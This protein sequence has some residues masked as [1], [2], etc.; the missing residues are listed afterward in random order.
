MS[1]PASSIVSV[2]PSV[3]A[4]GGNPLALNGLILSGN[5]LLPVGPPVSFPSAASVAAYFGNYAASFVGSCATNVLTVSQINSGTLA[6][7]QAVLG[8]SLPPNTYISSLGSG[9]GGVGTYNLSTTPGTIGPEAMTSAPLETAMAAV[10]FSGFN[11]S[12]TKPNALWFSKYASYS[13]AAFQCGASRSSLNTLATLHAITGSLVLNV[14]GLTF[15]AAAVASAFSGAASPSAAA[16]ALTALFTFSGAAVG[17]TITWSSTFNAFVVSTPVGS[18]TNTVAYATGTAA[19]A[20][21]LDA[22]SAGTLSQGSAA[23]TPAGAMAAVVLA[24]QNWAAFTTAFEPVAADK[25]AFA[26]WNS[27]TNGQFLYVP[28]DTDATAPTTA[29][30]TFTGLGAWLVTNSI[31]GTMPVYSDPLVAALM[32]GITASIDFTQHNGRTSFAFKSGSGLT[33][34]VSDLTSATNLLS[35][36]YN[37]YGAYATANSNFIWSQN[38]QISGPYLWADSYVNA[39]WLNNAMQLALM[40]MFANLKAVQYT[41][42]GYAMIEAALADP[43]NQALNFGVINPGVPLSAAQIAEVNAAAG[44]QIDQVIFTRGFYLQVLP[45]SA[46]VRANRQSPPCTLWYADGGAINRINLASIDIQ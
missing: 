29:P 44:L 32:L 4:A 19:S 17:T 7:G 3:L 11:N 43:I 34:T 6:V 22:A 36:G 13:I 2:T 12:N 31:S 16:L 21:G 46:S 42:A 26:T 23:M 10:Y 33:A 45:A 5:P 25:Q 40:N 30:G 28:Y 9:T 35:N 38:G 27:G 14:C 1:I 24:T 37:F 8:A 15:T 18:G 41:P 20:L 39:I